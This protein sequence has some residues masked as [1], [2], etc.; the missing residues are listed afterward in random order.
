M[1]A[2]LAKNIDFLGETYKIAQTLVPLSSMKRGFLEYLL[3]NAKMQFLCAGDTLFKKGDVE[4]K[5]F[6]LLSGHLKTKYASGY[7]ELIRAGDGDA[8]PIGEELPRQSTCVAK[9]DAT[10]LEIDSAELDRILS[11][12]QISEYLL[13][14]LSVQRDFDE[15]MDWIGTVL[16]SNL[17]YKVPPINAQKI[18]AKM[19]PVEVE[20]GEVIIREG[21]IGDCCYF[22]KEGD[23]EVTHNDTDDDTIVIAD[24]G[25]GRCFGEDALVYETV[26]NATVTM[27]SYGVLM[28]LNLNDF[29]TLLQEP[30]IEEITEEDMARFSDMPVLIDVRTQEEYESGHLSMAVN[31]PLHLLGLK[32]RL[33]RPS[34]TYVVYCDTGRRSKAAAFLLAEQGF[35][36]V[37]L[38]DGIVGAGMQY[39]LVNDFNYVLADGQVVRE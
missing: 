8:N 36:A 7:I 16:N 1:N 35:Q 19:T 32:Q 17:F 30:K 5:H 33:L 13:S 27:K 22:I 31:I 37:T 14:I 9:T 12:S 6:Y 24:I 25:P 34:T 11:W 28:R 10:V 38:R 23:A 15:D 21:E 26:R 2:E 18:L 20:A 29:K 3:K 39:Q 4:R